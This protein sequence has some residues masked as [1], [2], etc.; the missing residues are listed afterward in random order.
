M[1]FKLFEE[2]AKASFL[3]IEFDKY[4]FCLNLVL[5]IGNGPVS[6]FYSMKFKLFE[7]WAKASFQWIE[8]PP[9]LAGE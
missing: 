4:L 8:W 3:F 7:E 9:A 1:K 5:F 6:N 2:W